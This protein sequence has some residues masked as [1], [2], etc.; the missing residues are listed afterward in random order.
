MPTDL[1]DII[2][3]RIRLLDMPDDPDGIPPGTMG[4]R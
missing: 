2:G 4:H 1:G 3:K